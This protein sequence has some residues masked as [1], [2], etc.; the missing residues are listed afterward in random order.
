[1]KQEID[2][3][4]WY[5]ITKEQRSL[6]WN[7]NYYEDERFQEASDNHYYDVSIGKM[8]EFLGKSY[9]RSSDWKISEIDM[10]CDNLWDE[11]KLKLRTT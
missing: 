9:F 3:E 7:G 2:R 8:I 6:F 4:Q 1:M 10:L 5:E 11:V